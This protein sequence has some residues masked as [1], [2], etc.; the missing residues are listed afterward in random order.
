[1]AFTTIKPKQN[2]AVLESHSLAALCQSQKNKQHVDYSDWVSDVSQVVEAFVLYNRV[3][4]VRHPLYF[5]SGPPFMKVSNAFALESLLSATESEGLLGYVVLDAEPAENYIRMAPLVAQKAIFD[6]SEPIIFKATTEEE[7]H[8]YSI[9]QQ[10]VARRLHSAFLPSSK[11]A[12]TEHD[13]QANTE[14]RINIARQLLST[15]DSATRADVDSLKE[16]GVPVTLYIPPFLAIVLE[17]VSRGAD[18]GLA[19]LEIRQQF[20]AMRALVAEYESVLKD[21]SQPLKKLLSARTKI[22]SDIEK[23]SKALGRGTKVGIWEWADVL[24]AIPDAFDAATDCIIPQASLVRKLVELPVSKLRYF[25]LKR[26]YAALFRAYRD[27][28]R[29]SNYSSLVYSTFEQFEN[30]WKK[31]SGQEYAIFQF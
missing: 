10:E 23:I 29:I 9:V 22:F 3:I 18:F 17:K 2:D 4:V 26:R 5:E 8:E 30:Q 19:V 15:L 7:H 11:S 13:I 16:I 25:L 27:F 20:T 12:L 28:H 6:L 1:M 21:T 31:D 24:D 14:Q